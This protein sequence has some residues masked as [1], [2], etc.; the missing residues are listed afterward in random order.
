MKWATALSALIVSAALAG[1]TSAYENEP[2][3]FRGVDWDTP[4]D[5]L[6][7][8]FAIV[9][10]TP[11]TTGNKCYLR[12]GDKMQLGGAELASIYYCFYRDRFHS[13]MLE[14]TKTFA[15]RQALQEAFVSQFG[16]G[17]KPNQFIERWLWFGAVTGISL[18]C[19]P[20][21]KHCRAYL[22]SRTV[23]GREKEDRAKKAEAS[24]QDF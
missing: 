7:D 12:R 24:K 3:G 14:T 17:H 5:S 21:Q 6:G 16:A 11:Q 1:T 15:S 4:I 2:K 13:V 9:Q 10:G 22:F 19:S 23:A 18:E 20:V 8:Q